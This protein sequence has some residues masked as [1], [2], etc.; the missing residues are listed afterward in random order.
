M[1]NLS[2]FH[3]THQ[4]YI[5]ATARKCISQTTIVP[6]IHLLVNKKYLW[7]LYYLLL[8]FPLR[9]IFL[10]C[11][12]IKPVLHLV[13]PIFHRNTRKIIK[14]IWFTRVRGKWL[15]LLPT[16]RSP[17]KSH[18]LPTNIRITSDVVYRRTSSIQR[19]MLRNDERF[20]I[21]YTKTG[22]S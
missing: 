21:S 22:Y 16:S 3:I 10:V 8:R 20:V 11:I 2:N 15:K 9:M 7:Y 6:S 13:P 18:L 4:W 1:I 17:S 14:V 12:D 19:C 5:K